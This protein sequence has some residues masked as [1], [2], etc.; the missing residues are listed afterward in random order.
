MPVPLARCAFSRSSSGTSTVILR[1]VSI[2]RHYT[3]LDTSIEY[4]PGAHGQAGSVRDLEGAAADAFK[5]SSPK[6]SRYFS[7]SCVLVRWRGPSISLR[8]SI[9][10]FIALYAASQV[11]AHPL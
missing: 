1:A 9:S 5:E 8:I 2:T 7:L 10:V 11:I 4:G 6:T 3:I